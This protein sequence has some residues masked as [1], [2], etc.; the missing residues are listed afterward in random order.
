VSRS[1]IER[2][3]DKY[4]HLAS[5]IGISQETIRGMASS[6]S[7]EMGSGAPAAKKQRQPSTGTGFNKSKYQQ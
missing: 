7:A 3:V 4:G 1:F 2:N 5:K 6:L